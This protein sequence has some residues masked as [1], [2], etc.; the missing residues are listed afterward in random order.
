MFHF[1][2]LCVRFTFIYN[3]RPFALKWTQI[4]HDEAQSAFNRQNLAFMLSI[5]HAVI[6][7]TS[8]NSVS[9]WQ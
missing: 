7:V 9:V 4:E 2:Q 1:I 3:Y 6:N 5:N 8:Y